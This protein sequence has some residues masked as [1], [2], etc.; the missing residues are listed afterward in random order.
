MTD[1]Y[2]Y[3]L[4]LL[5]VFAAIQAGYIGLN[6]AQRIPR[7]FAL[8]RRLL[9]AGSAITLAVG[10]WSMHFI[11]I[12]AIKTTTTIDY[13]VL[14]TLIS[15]L[16]CV[17]VTG[18]AIYMASLRSKR[19][20]CFAALFMGIGIA[21]MHYVG[22]MALR[23]SAMM[24]H[25]PA[26]IAASVIFA[27]S[28]SGIALWMAFL[29]SE[30]FPPIIGAVIFSFAVCSMHYTAM[31]GMTMNFFEAPIETATFISSDVLAMIVS[32]V[33]FLISAVFMLTLVPHKQ[34]VHQSDPRWSALE[35]S[36]FPIAEQQADELIKEEA[37]IA[38]TFLNAPSLIP[39]EKNGNQF[40]IST[41]DVISIHANAHY[42]Y[43]FNGRDDLF[44]PLS[45]SEIGEFLDSAMFFRTHRSYI[46]N[47][48]HIE[49]IQKSGDA[50]V[51]ELSC[52][53][54]RNV[55]VARARVSQLRSEWTDF[56]VNHKTAAP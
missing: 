17:L 20:I 37:L 27:I 32:F 56:K 53:I 26:Y 49:R 3:Y 16:V 55:P 50:A 30:R 9:I 12:L 51:V 7:A 11:G 46:V 8:N 45:I 34:P 22:M 42:T 1:T 4:V 13:L 47:L 29:A 40:Q 39:I 44:C 19:M 14:P 2:N 35:A 54:R 10:I 18:L 31:A 24:A 36:I 25:N 48:H 41:N 5:S 43:I 6:L 28:A 21:A 15:F 33:A 23:T 52:A 38:K